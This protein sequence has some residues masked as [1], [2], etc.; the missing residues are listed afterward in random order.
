MSD[1]MATMLGELVEDLDAGIA[2]GA[3]S[4][5]DGAALRDR[6]ER[7]AEVDGMDV[8]LML[9]GLHW[10]IQV[11]RAEV[12]PLAPDPV[13]TDPP[14]RVCRVCRRS[15]YWRRCP[16]RGPWVCC[17]CHTSATE[18]PEVIDV[19][20]ERAAIQAE[21]EMDDVDELLP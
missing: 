7:I 4:T 21:A 18:P 12:P 5:Y 6:Y 8:A 14:D 16:G 17:R 9:L 13:A 3:E 15:R 19:D 1:V 11:R 20:P 2:N 10:C